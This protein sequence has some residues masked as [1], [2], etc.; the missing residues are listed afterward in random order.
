MADTFV[1]ES[2]AGDLSRREWVRLLDRVAR[3]V[4]SALCRRQ[5]RQ[6]MPLEEKE[7][8]G[9]KEVTYL[10]A[11]GRT[12]LGL[13]PWLEIIHSDPEEE[14]LAEEYRNMVIAAIDAATDPASPDCMDFSFAHGRQP[15]VDAAFLSHALLRAPT[16]ILAALPPGCQKNLVD[17]LTRLR[18][19]GMPYQN[20]WL[21]F[22]A[23]IEAALCRLGENWDWMRVDYAVRRM[24]DWY[25]GDGQYA[26]G[27][28]FHWDYYNS[29]VIQPMLADIL[30]T[31]GDFDPY[32][33][34]LQQPVLERSARYA[35]VLER[36]I[37]PDGTFPVIGRSIAYRCGAFQSLA[38]MALMERLPPELP[39]EQARCALSAVIQRT[40][41]VPGTFDDGGWL[42]IGLAGSQ[43]SLGET[44]ISTGSLYLCTAAFLPL[45]L[46]RENP[47]WSGKACPWTSQKI[48]SG[49]DFPLDHAISV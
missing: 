14:K 31:V 43:P 26:D 18:Y 24:E 10:E 13:T 1:K 42:K 11:L 46:P 35:A 39:P 23:M 29:F 34:S 17:C 28:S 40:L 15:I 5:L 48:W 47:F 12:L 6:S 7:G 33:K 19:H 41:C 8:S 38:Q 2:V 37:A 32:W 44:Y 9:R 22:S 36:M 21:L 20:N 4:L 45:G 3:P 49:Q 30:L 27:P 25:V 16:R